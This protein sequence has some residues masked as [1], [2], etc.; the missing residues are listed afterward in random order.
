MARTNKKATVESTGNPKGIHGSHKAISRL[1]LRI[2]EQPKDHG[3]LH[4]NKPGS[5]NR[6]K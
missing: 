3:G 6:K 2:A 5:E 1:D 4:Y